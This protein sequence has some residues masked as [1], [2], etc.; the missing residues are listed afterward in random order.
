MKLSEARAVLEGIIYGPGP[1]GETR[2]RARRIDRHFQEWMERG[3]DADILPSFCISDIPESLDL[4]D[5][6]VEAAERA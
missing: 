2:A 6:H 5:K 4:W 1:D 3:G